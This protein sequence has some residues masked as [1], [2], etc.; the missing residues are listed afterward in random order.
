[1][2]KTDFHRRLS[3]DDDGHT[4]RTEQANANATLAG[5]GQAL[6]SGEARA[7]HEARHLLTQTHYDMAIERL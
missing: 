5:L 1:M 4:T 6:S 3:L 2:A 7:Y